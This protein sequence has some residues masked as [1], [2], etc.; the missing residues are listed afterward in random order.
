MKKFTIAIL[1]IL[2]TLVAC[3]SSNTTPKVEQ[4]NVETVVAATL[5][6][7]T[8]NAPTPQPSGIPVSFQNVSF[9]IPQGLA[10]GATGELIPA[11]TEEDGGPWGVAPEYISFTLTG[12]TGRD[13]SYFKATVNVY[14]MAEYATV[15]S[16]AESSI[17]RLQALL[18]SPSGPLTNETLP[19]IPSN[20]AA[21]QQYA[22][23]AKLIGFNGGNG[24]RLISQYSQFPGPILK[25]N[26]LFHYE[27]ITSDGKYLV[28]VLFPVHLPLQTTAEN[29]SAD[30][31]QFPSDPMDSVAIT[32][33]YQGM[34]DLLN[35]A[36]GD[37]FQP[38]LALLDELI[39]SI[40]IDMP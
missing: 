20:G 24:V 10:N 31:I 30:G 21:A 23:Q 27:G 35:A 5:Q 17:T 26:S 37:S 40:T 3:N 11:V 7:V 16:W 12:Y 2:L 9:V 34:T 14:P 18:A 39:Q 33:Y 32:A 25:D 22:A 28:A 15:N 19:T 8:E 1:V 6:A 4:P 29:P 38:S 13:D 36:S